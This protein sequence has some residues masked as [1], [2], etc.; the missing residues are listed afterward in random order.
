MGTGGCLTACYARG[1][2]GYAAAFHNTTAPLSRECNSRPA[3]GPGLVARGDRQK[4]A[5]RV[6]GEA[7]ASTSILRPS[8]YCCK[9]EWQTEGGHRSQIHQQPPATAA[10]AIREPSFFQSKHHTGH[11]APQPRLGERLPPHRSAPSIEEVP[12]LRDRGAVLPVRSA[13]V[14]PVSG[15]CDLYQGNAGSSSVVAEQGL[16]SVAL[17]R[18]LSVRFQL[19]AGGSGGNGNHRRRLGQ[20]GSQTERSEGL[21]DAHNV[22]RSFGPAS[23]HRRDAFQ[24]NSRHRGSIA[25][26]RRRHQNDRIKAAAASAGERARTLLWSGGLAAAGG[27]R[28]SYDAQTAARCARDSGVDAKQSAPVFG[29]VVRAGVV[30]RGA[31]ERRSTRAIA[32]ADHSYVDRRIGCGLGRRTARNHAARERHVHG[33]R[34]RYHHHGPR[35]ASGQVR[36]DVLRHESARQACGVVD[37]QPGSGV[38]SDEPHLPQRRGTECHSRHLAASK[39]NESKGVGDLAAVGAQHG[40]RRA[41]PRGGP[42]RLAAEAGIIP[43]AVRAVGDT[44]RRCVRFKSEYPVAALLRSTTGA[45]RVGGRRS[46]AELARRRPVLQSALA[47]DRRS[48]VKAGADAVGGSDSGPTVLAGGRVVSKAASAGSGDA[49]GADRQQHVQAQVDGQCAR[50][51]GSILEFAAGARAT[52]TLAVLRPNE[53]VGTLQL[54]G[55]SL[56]Q[57][58]VKQYAASLALVHRFCKQSDAAVVP[59]APATLLR[60]LMWLKSG[61]RVHGGTVRKYVAAVVKVHEWMA[62]PSPLADPVVR[63]AV[64]GFQRITRPRT[65]RLDRVPLLLR[66]MRQIVAAGLKAVRDGRWPVAEACA[67]VL[68]QFIFFARASTL[69]AQRLDGVEFSQNVLVVRLSYEK[70]DAEPGRRVSFGCAKVHSWLAD[71]PHPFFLLRTWIEWR[72][73]RGGVYLLSGP[74]RQHEYVSQLWRVACEAAAVQPVSGR[75][76]PHSARSG[77]ASA[78]AAAGVSDT[79]LQVRGGWRSAGTLRSYVYEVSRHKADILYFGELAPTVVPFR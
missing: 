7:R 23:G 16:G 52:G 26:V 20:L 39:S 17:P 11:V 2:A 68:W 32:Q 61:D 36:V 4:L 12:R 67:A 57:S 70:G 46:G 48:G 60:F 45:K 22:H 38:R 64:R 49:G 51:A 74:R 77:G 33:T 59:M 58:T 78:A 9:R 35:A 72:K 15:A 56:A 6:V 30:V 63:A 55:G 76:L 8:I 40:G 75:Y 14:R 31:L 54:L 1:K 66:D 69:V 73:S 24:I 21:L 19:T 71:E 3:R 28:S 65:V 10:C 29:S 47:A 27:A 43:A 41:V 44:T 37:R 53:L 18:R 34:V 5:A 25:C 62:L 50:A 42:Q 79:V 13:A